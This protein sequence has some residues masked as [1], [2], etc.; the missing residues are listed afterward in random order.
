MFNFTF[1]S[2]FAGLS[3]LCFRKFSVRCSV[4]MFLVLYATACTQNTNSEAGQNESVDSQIKIGLI[5]KTETN[6][7]FVKMKEGAQTQSELLGVDLITATGTFDGD[8]DSQIAAIEEMITAG[9]SGILITPSDSNKIVPAI[10]KARQA[11]IIVIALDS[12]TDPVDATDALYATDNYKAGL[13]IGEYART[14]VG[15]TPV[16][17]A[18]LNLAPGITVS[19]LRRS[20]FLDG[21]GIPEGDPQIVCE[22]DTNGDESM[23]L[24][25][26][27]SCL[28]ED[29]DINLVYTINEPAAFG[30][31]SALKTVGREQSTLIVSVDGGCEGIE[32]VN[33]GRIG[34]TSQQYPLRMAAQGIRSIVNAV[35]GEDFKSGYTDTGV[36][37]ITNDSEYGGEAEDGVFGISNC[38]GEPS[39]GALETAKAA[40]RSDVVI[41]L[42]VKT[43][44]NPFFLKMKEGAQN[45]ADELGV[46]L[47]TAAGTFDGD[48][49]SQVVAIEEMIEAGALGILITPSDSRAIVPAIEKAQAAGVIVIALD[50]P[51]DP[52][53]A[54]NALYATDNFK[55]GVLIGE[56]ARQVTNNESSKIALLNL[57]TGISVS[58]LRRAGFLEGYGIE[59]DDPQIVCEEDTNGDEALGQ[60]AMEKCLANDPDIDVV[61]TI[62]EPAAFGAHT[63][64][65][66][67][68]RAGDVLIVSVDGG[69]AGIEAIIDGRIAATSQQFPLRMASLGIENIV[70]AANGSGFETGYTSTGLLLITNDRSFNGASEDAVI[71]IQTCWGEPSEGALEAAEESVTRP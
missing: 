4:L 22:A 9:V 34:A 15:N 64:I 42:I 2:N 31:Y 29:P 21:Y 36:I 65:E 5:T 32:A 23:G 68:G 63:A 10:E 28:A 33:D 38:W 57:S 56:Y 18:L 47:L 61:Y 3:K 26:M 51:T 37:L 25:A 62:N 1:L 50:T 39:E 46:T 13:L 27:E 8:N 6:P 55:A 45:K 60:A 14:K 52:E 70:K 48:N 17:I 7:F 66:A 40:S 59:D 19:Q 43:E 11:G 30:A 24:S 12:P 71:G 49:E 69:C 54:T 44:N 41:G 58:E 35:N 67:A 20:G 53:D 16:K